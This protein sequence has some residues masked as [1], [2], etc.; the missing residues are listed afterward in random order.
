MMGVS[1]SGKST[2]GALLSQRTGW[3]F[4]DAD[5]LHP[6]SNVIKM[7]AGIPLTDA[8]R[9]PWLDQVANWITQ[10]I[11]AGECGIVGCSALKRAYR[12][13][14]RRADSRLPVVYLRGDRDAPV[15]RPTRPP[16]HSF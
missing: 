13:R 8:D 7:Q 5:D 1:G 10:R 2:I 16:G 4:L 3:P 9:W 11:Q 6:A 12:D 15:P 14:L